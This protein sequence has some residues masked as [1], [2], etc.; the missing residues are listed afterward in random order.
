[1]ALLQTDLTAGKQQQKQWVAQSIAEKSAIKAGKELTDMEMQL[2]LEQLATC[3]D[4]TY[5]PSGKALAYC[6]NETE[7]ENKL[8]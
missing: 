6:L 1:M 2:M 7:I 5:S 3:Q 8:K 4:A